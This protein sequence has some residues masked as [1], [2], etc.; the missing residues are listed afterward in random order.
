M[1]NNGGLHEIDICENDSPSQGPIYPSV[2]VPIGSLLAD[3]VG[4]LILI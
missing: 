1:G 3:V 2:V 4:I